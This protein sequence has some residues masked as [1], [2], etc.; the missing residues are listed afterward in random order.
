M[1]RKTHFELNREIKMPRKMGFMANALISYAE[2][3]KIPKYEDI[4]SILSL[5]REI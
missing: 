2:G 5:D 3:L 1:P 4:F